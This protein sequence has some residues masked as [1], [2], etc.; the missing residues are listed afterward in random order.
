[1]KCPQCGTAIPD[2][3][4]NCGKCRMNVY[5]A[6]QHYSQL[7]GIRRSQGLP[8]AAPT[9]SFLVRVHRDAMDDRATRGGREE[10]RVRQVARSIMRGTAPESEPGD[11]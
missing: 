2:S 3:E 6:S 8:P 4:W 9:P 1:M 5:W 10:H 7:A 11:G